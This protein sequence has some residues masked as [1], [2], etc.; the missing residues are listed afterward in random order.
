MI[1]GYVVVS[2]A[3]VLIVIYFTMELD[4]LKDHLK[5]QHELIGLLI[6]IADQQTDINAAQRGFN[7]SSMDL[8][9]AQAEAIGTNTVS[10][11][12]LAK[13]DLSL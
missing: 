12:T 5:D 9:K 1:T 10:I 11:E 13:S 7:T 4:A 6:K 8:H 3:L 2:V